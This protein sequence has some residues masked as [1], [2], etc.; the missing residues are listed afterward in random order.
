M[1]FYDA[2]RFANWMSNGQGGGDT[3]TGAYTLLG[4]AATPSNGDTVI[5]NAGAAIFLPTRDEWFKA[6]YYEASSTSYNLFATRSNS[7]PN[8]VAPTAAPNSANCSDIGAV[9]DLTPVGGYTGSPSPYGTFDQAG[10]VR[11]WNETIESG[12]RVIQGGSFLDPAGTTEGGSIHSA[13]QGNAILG[14][15]LVMIP[16]PGS[17]L[18]VLTGVLGLAGWRRARA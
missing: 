15:R 6:A 1:G 7:T 9:G 16:E 18:L 13:D 4:G 2:L 11:E 8:C 5:R 14:F 17:G 12:G 10:N 3:K